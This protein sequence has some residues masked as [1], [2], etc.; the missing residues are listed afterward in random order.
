MQLTRPTWR[1]TP[2]HK[3]VFGSLSK[4]VVAAAKQKSEETF[5][6]ALRRMQKVEQKG[7]DL[8]DNEIESR[9]HTCTQSGLGLIIHNR[10]GSG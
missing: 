8:K 9:K 6:Q 5:Q 7:A 10:S 4:L 1:L 2:L 3:A